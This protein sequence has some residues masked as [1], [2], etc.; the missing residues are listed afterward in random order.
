MKL[1]FLLGTRPEVI[2][3]SPLIREASMRGIPFFIMHTGQHYSHDMDGRFFEEFGLPEPA[4]HLG[5][6]SSA[7]HLQG[8]HTGKMLIAIERV[9][10][11]E[12]PDIVIVQGDTNTVLAGAL[13]VRKLRTA[14]SYLATRLAHVEG[15]LRSFDP[16]MTEELNRMV[17]DQLSDYIFA[18]SDTAKQH[19]IREGIGENRIFVVGN[20]IVDAVMH[21]TAN[22][23]A[24]AVLKD[25]G[26]S[27][28]QYFFVTAHRQENVD[29]PKK[30][31]GILEGLRR[32]AERFHLPA[33]YSLHPRTAKRMEEFGFSFPS[34]V[35]VTRPVGFFD[36]LKFQKEARLILTDSGGLQ[37][38]AS[39]LGVS[40][41]TLRDFTERPET[42]SAGV[43]ALAGTDPDRIEA[44]VAQ[45]MEKTHEWR[46]LYGDGTAAKQIMDVLCGSQL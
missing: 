6:R 20:T 46:P 15:G 1:C 9:L 30:F 42:V 28:K 31:G 32:I 24:S 13:A 41:V 38:E 37:E 16:S 29:D 21:A 22:A 33:V 18:P 23:D 8:E 14:P 40:C 39:I 12:K 17:A 34:G 3:L 26:L 44:A 11:A 45:M 4:Y 2:K 25:L 19:L 5:I 10:L 36:S 35:R 27:P 7:S 43:N